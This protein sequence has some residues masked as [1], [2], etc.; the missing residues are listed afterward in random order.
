MALT[1]KKNPLLSRYATIQ[2]G[3]DVQKPDSDVLVYAAGREDTPILNFPARP[4]AASA[5]DRPTSGSCCRTWQPAD[6]RIKRRIPFARS[7]SISCAM[8]RRALSAY[9]LSRPT[10]I[11]NWPIRRLPRCFISSITPIL[12]R[13]SRPSQLFR[14]LTGLWRIST[15]AMRNGGGGLE[16]QEGRR[17]E[18]RRP[19][20][21]YMSKK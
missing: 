3:G 16:K 15:A 21:A 19:F 6:A 4:P 7:R 2:V 17:R 12:R 20:G 5:R 1:G 10:S 13:R 8:S 9:A 18:S 14:R 11:M